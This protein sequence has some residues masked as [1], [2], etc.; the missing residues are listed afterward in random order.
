MI[1]VF[2]DICDRDMNEHMCSTTSKEE[3][4]FSMWS[5]DREWDICDEC[6]RDL[7]RWITERR[8]AAKISKVV[9]K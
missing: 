4:V 1:K 5:F 9:I 7:N 2:C 6:R 3:R 8:E